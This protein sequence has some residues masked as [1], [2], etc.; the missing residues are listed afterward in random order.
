MAD[1]Y[2]D[3][4]GVLFFYKRGIGVVCLNSGS[5]PLNTISFIYCDWTDC[6]QAVL[7]DRKFGGMARFKHETTNRKVNVAR[8]MKLP[9]Q[10][11]WKPLKAIYPVK[12]AACKEWIAKNAPILWHVKHKLVMHVD[13]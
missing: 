13:C 6:L 12:C 5:Y 2:T 1:L 9:I 4:F 7:A 3:H 11:D 10:D 8:G